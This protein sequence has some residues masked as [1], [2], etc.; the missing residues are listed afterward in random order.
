LS[1]EAIAERGR[2]PSQSRSD[3]LELR[4]PSLKL[5]IAG[6]F[7]FAF[8]L[9]WVVLLVEPVLRRKDEAT[10]AV[11]LAVFVVALLALGL[12]R[13]SGR[14]AALCLVL[15]IG[16]CW[17]LAARLHPP[18][19]VLPWLALL[20]ILATALLG[21]A[22]GILLGAASSA[23][24]LVA[25]ELAPG[26]D[27]AAI[28]TTQGMIWAAIALSW[29]VTRPLNTALDW[30]WRSYEQALAKTREAEHHRG[31]LAR[32]LKGMEELCYRLEVANRELARAREAAD[33]ALRLKA[34]FA[35]LVSHELRIPLNIVTGFCEMMVTS[36]GS[37]DDQQL[38]PPYRLDLEAMWR[39]ARHL[40]DLVDDVLDLSQLDAHEM[41]LVKEPTSIA[42]VV[43]QAGAVVSPLL[44]GKGLSFEVDVPPDLPSVSADGVR[45]RQVIANLLKNALRFTDGGGVRL[46]VAAREG[47]VV[48]SVADTGIGIGPED[49]PHVFEEFHQFAAAG[50]RRR[51][52]TGL[53]L[54]ISKRL[55]ELHGGS[56]WLESRPSG[57]TTFSFSLPLCDNVAAVPVRDAWETWARVAPAAPALDGPVVAVVGRD[58]QAIRLLQRHLDGYRVVPTPAH[59]VLAELAASD[60]VRAVVVAR[61]MG[62]EE[63]SGDD[64]LSELCA[65]LPAPVVACAVQTG[66]ADARELGVAEYL[67]KPVERAALD[68]ALAAYPD[69]R[70]AV[71]VDDDPEMARL[72]A[73]MLRSLRPDCRV[74]TA[75]DGAEALALIRAHRPDVVLLD[76]LLPEVD[77]YE[78]LRRLRADDD[79]RDTPVVVVT[80]AEPTGSVV[81]AEIGAVTRNGG[82]ARG[83]FIRCLQAILDSFQP[84][85][86][87][88]PAPREALAV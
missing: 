58:Q 53:G 18:D 24:L 60:P 21:S 66:R 28:A 85:H 62:H 72:L 46:S 82:L 76:L 63:D 81:R 32:A 50:P 6:T 75:F 17:L 15:G 9:L 61:T 59:G 87:T 2:T 37:Y 74:W 35:A 43:A 5:A 11:A 51:G 13:L 33:E 14:L 86:G 78:V 19:V 52:G 39:A 73:A 65:A 56:M 70:R 83:E 57:G 40:A 79:L 36:P 26:A 38:P 68:G 29:L 30:S 22:G 7:G 80:A 84:P 8:A 88:P 77:G 34:R 31:E 4:Q 64:L 27:G 67:L 12:G 1:A 45:L 42:E 47:E 10:A 20:T 3:R 71:V 16:G 49:L 23:A 44:A 41:P 48:V 54:T 69:L 25:P 55:V